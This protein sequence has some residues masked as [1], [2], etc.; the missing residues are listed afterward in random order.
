M[1]NGAPLTDRITLPNY[2]GGR[3][4]DSR[5]ENTAEVINPATQEVL[6]RVPQGPGTAADVNDAVQAAAR[7]FPAWSRTPV[8]RRVQPLYML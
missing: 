2:I 1:Q 3:W 4:V 5:E 7:A 8:M 6:G